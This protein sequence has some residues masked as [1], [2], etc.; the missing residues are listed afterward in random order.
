MHG[1]TR[2]YRKMAS[3]PGTATPIPS[4]TRPVD[5]GGPARRMWTDRGL[6]GRPHPAAPPHHY[7]FLDSRGPQLLVRAPRA[8][9]LSVSA[10]ETK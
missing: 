10:G 9:V 5:S 7:A 6:G 4:I 3:V 1:Q 2:S 8:S